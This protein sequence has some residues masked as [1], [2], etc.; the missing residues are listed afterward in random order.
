MTPTK[1]SRTQLSSWKK[2][3]S[4]SLPLMNR[5]M[6]ALLTALLTVLPSSL[7]L[8]QPCLAKGKGIAGPVVD[9]LSSLVPPVVA[10]FGA[11]EVAME[12][13]T[14]EYKYTTSYRGVNSSTRYLAE[15]NNNGKTSYTKKL[16]MSGV[17]NPI[18]ITTS[19][20][21]SISVGG[22]EGDIPFSVRV[23]NCVMPMGNGEFF[24]ATTNAKI[25][26]KVTHR[27]K[28]NPAYMSPVTDVKI[29]CSSWDRERFNCGEVS[30]IS[31]EIFVCP[32]A[33]NGISYPT[34]PNGSP[35]NLT[36]RGGAGLGITW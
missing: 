33:N 22:S 7:L 2:L 13:H 25:T 8:N 35:V 1:D 14:Y 24:S 5:S 10:A 28:V 19:D 23:H 16:Q 31:T 15:V 9:G 29:T 18:N 6:S 4:K 11:A 3:N 21:F 12:L 27:Y 26:F 36:H 34:I 17:D 32:I 30:G 20:P